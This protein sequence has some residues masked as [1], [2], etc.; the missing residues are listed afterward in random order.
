MQKIPVGGEKNLKIFYLF[1]LDMYFF[2][3]DV[4]AFL[5]HFFWRKRN[6]AQRKHVRWN[7]LEFTSQSLARIFIPINKASVTRGIN[8]TQ[9]DTCNP[10]DD[11]SWSKF[12]KFHMH[13]LALLCFFVC[14]IVLNQAY[15]LARQ[16]RASATKL[17][18][19]A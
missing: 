9:T 4:R 11:R 3:L 18:V 12:K 16:K 6:A 19:R 10:I 2:S 17:L 5:P 15:G 7:F 14:F 8:P 1:V 13:A